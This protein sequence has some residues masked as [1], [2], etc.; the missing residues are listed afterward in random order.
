MTEKPAFRTSAAA[1]VILSLSAVPAMAGGR[2]GHSYPVDA[3]TTLAKVARACN[4]SL[5]AL[6]EANPGVD[7]GY[8]SPG[9]HLA[10]PDEI[11]N[12]SDVPAG[13][14]NLGLD[15]SGASP[16]PIY[17][18]VEYTEPARRNAD[19]KTSAQSSSYGSTVSPYY[20]QASLGGA[21]RFVR[22]NENLSYQKRSAARIRNAGLPITTTSPAALAPLRSTQPR[23]MEVSIVT[24]LPDFGKLS[25]DPVSP[26]M[27]CSVLRRQTDGKI[28]QVREF[29]PLPEG[30]DTPPHC[31]AVSYTAPGAGAVIS[32]SAYPAL[33]PLEEI[34]VLHG[35]VSHADAECVTLRADDG[36]V[37]RVGVALAPMELLGKD[38]TIWAEVTDAPSCGGL[39]L[40][41]AVYAERI[42]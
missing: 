8:V 38:A 28:S 4:V 9:E 5:A 1:L 29:K 13:G 37:W 17:R 20:V 33:P 39:V 41:R 7:P 12:A 34:A 6:R 27:E 19:N 18:Y 26:L 24:D 31:Q 11:D 2:C 23:A 10:V 22:E 21:P 15:N 36:M 32:R 16:A 30:R 42:R 40:D 3:P 25:G 35:Y 14:A